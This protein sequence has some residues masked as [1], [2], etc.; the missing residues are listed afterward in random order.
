MVTQVVTFQRPDSPHIPCHK[1]LLFL[2]LMAC[3]SFLLLISA[4][5]ITMSPLDPVYP[6]VLLWKIEEYFFSR[7]LLS[8]VANHW[9]GKQ[10]VGHFFSGLCLVYA[11]PDPQHLIS[12]FAISHTE[13]MV[14]HCTEKRHYLPPLLFPATQTV[15]QQQKVKWITKWL[16]KA[17]DAPNMP[18]E[19]LTSIKYLLALGRTCLFGQN[20]SCN[21]E[22]MRCSA[23][24][25]SHSWAPLY[26]IWFTNKGDYDILFPSS[27]VTILLPFLDNVGMLSVPNRLTCKRR[28]PQWHQWGTV[29]YLYGEHCRE[30]INHCLHILNVTVTP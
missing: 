21:P 20:T 23:V 17:V 7:Y 29:G 5:T 4:L 11:T 16:T 24:K 14:S 10:H 28:D 25:A 19:Q 13:R 8:R 12:A 3:T 15:Q 26:S 2:S 6:R 22:K 9:L 18:K 1:C 30:T 27:F